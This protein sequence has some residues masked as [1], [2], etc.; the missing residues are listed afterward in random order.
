MK[1]VRLLSSVATRID[2]V[3]DER[4]MLKIELLRGRDLYFS[5]WLLILVMERVRSED[6]E[7]RKELSEEI[8]KEC[9][10]PEWWVSL[11]D[12]VRVFRL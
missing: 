4:E 10:A 6:E 7:I 5:S 2:W 1:I 8:F 9:T 3:C 12:W 11:N